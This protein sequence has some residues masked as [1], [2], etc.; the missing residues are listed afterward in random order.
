MQA[1]SDPLRLTS[2]IGEKTI[3]NSN[4]N[5]SGNFTKA[6]VVYESGEPKS[7][8]VIYSVPNF[9][10]DHPN[11]R[12]TEEIVQPDSGAVAM[13]TGIVSAQGFNIVN[14]GAV[15]FENSQ[16]RG[17]GNLFQSSIP[18]LSDSFSQGKISG[19]SSLIITGGIWNFYTG[20]NYTG[21]R[22]AIN[23]QY[24]LGPGQ[25]NLGCLPV[26]DLIKSMKYIRAS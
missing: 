25:Y 7:F 4:A 24:D 14:P 11:D 3:Y 12:K 18:D 17:Y 1:P 13:Q 9:D 8:W 6:E 2:T 15:L 19:V 23:G 16:Y 10:H 21:T 22:I 5:I 26:N 20:F